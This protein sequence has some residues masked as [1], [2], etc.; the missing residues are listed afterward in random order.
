MPRP[1]MEHALVLDSKTVCG[2]EQ[3]R[4]GE[5]RLPETRAQWIYRERCRRGVGTAET[6]QTSGQDLVTETTVWLQKQNGESQLFVDVISHIETNTVT[7][8]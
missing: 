5:V 2:A 6:E 3:Q 4:A 8:R 1:R 7:R